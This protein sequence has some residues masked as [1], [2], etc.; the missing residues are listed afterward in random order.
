MPPQGPVT[1]EQPATIPGEQDASGTKEPKP[2]TTPLGA[3][4]TPFESTRVEDN[5]KRHATVLDLRL[6]EIVIDDE[7]PEQT[8]QG[9]ES[10]STYDIVSSGSE[11]KDGEQELTH[12]ES[13]NIGHAVNS[14]DAGPSS[15]LPPIR[16]RPFPL[17]SHHPLFSPNLGARTVQLIRLVSDDTSPGNT[18]PREFFSGPSHIHSGAYSSETIWPL[19]SSSSFDMGSTTSLLPGHGLHMLEVSEGSEGSEEVQDDGSAQ[20]DVPP[21]PIIVFREREMSDE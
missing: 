17:E 14:A 6:S 16:P 21:R 8:G 2:T 20:D 9:Q 11:H 10:G 1:G 19:S 18:I 5:E 15:I 4:S 13:H 3:S 12:P 7:H